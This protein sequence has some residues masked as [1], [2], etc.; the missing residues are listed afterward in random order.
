MN[1]VAITMRG[2]APD[3][4][5]AHG[6]HRAG[7]DETSHMQ[8]ALHSGARAAETLAVMDAAPGRHPRKSHGQSRAKT[9][10]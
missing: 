10:G 4:A 6:P 2:G 5:P 9:P 7:D 3:H 8:A 1:R